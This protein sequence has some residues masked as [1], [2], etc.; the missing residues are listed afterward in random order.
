MRHPGSPAP[1]QV[2][3]GSTTGRDRANP[4]C[5]RGRR[6]ARRCGAGRGCPHGPERAGCARDESG[7]DSIDDRVCQRSILVRLRGRFRRGGRVASARRRPA[8]ARLPERKLRG[9]GRAGGRGCVPS[10]RRHEAAPGRHVSL[11]RRCGRD[12][13]DVVLAG[14]V[15]RVPSCCGGAPGGNGGAAPR[16]GGRLGGMGAR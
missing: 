11:G 2:F 1:E 9:C 10:T 13:R 12:D 8:R 6:D 15:P 3:H 5:R 4:G 7:N 14:E 16:T